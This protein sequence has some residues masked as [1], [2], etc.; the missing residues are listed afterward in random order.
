MRRSTKILLALLVLGVIAR[1]GLVVLAPSRWRLNAVERRA[2]A[3]GLATLE[4]KL[5]QRRRRFVDLRVLTLDPSHAELVVID[6]P[7]KAESGAIGEKLLAAGCR[8]GVTGGYFDATFA[9]VGLLVSCGRELHP[10]KA[11]GP[12]GI[13]CVAKDGTVRLLT[14][15]DYQASAPE[16][17]HAVQAGPFIVGPGGKFG[18]RTRDEK[19]RRRVAACLDDAGGVHLVVTDELS[20][21]ELAELLLDEKLMGMK[22][23]RAL[24]LDGG[25][26]AALWCGEDALAPA[27]PVRSLIGVMPRD[28]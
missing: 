25:P 1:I 2:V 5:L 15:G 3:D 4:T 8:A 22:V 11:D 20:L 23:E 10:V 6:V 7:E 16:C 9:P 21:W 24:N 18:I 27:G 12:S 13:F 19:R 26:S 17:R 28:Q 14:L